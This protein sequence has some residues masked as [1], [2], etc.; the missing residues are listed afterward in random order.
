MPPRKASVIA[1]LNLKT[2]MVTVDL[3]SGQITSDTI[4]KKSGYPTITLDDLSTAVKVALSNEQVKDSI[5]HRGVALSDLTCVP[6]SAGWFGP[7]EENGRVIKVICFSNQGT[8]NF[9][10]RPIEG[11]TVTVDIDRK[12]VVKISDTGRNIPI[13]RS[14]NTDYTYKGQAEKNPL[15]PISIEQ[16]NGPSFIVEDGH[17]V[18]WANWE[19]HLKADQRAGL[20]ISRAMVRDPVTDELRSVMYKGF[21]SELFVPYMDVDESWYFK[22]YMDAGEYGMGANAMPLVE[23]ND[24]PKYSYY[25]DGVFVAA[26]GKPFV[27]RNVICLFERYAGD[28]SWRHSELPVLGFQVNVVLDCSDAFRIRLQCFISTFWLNNRFK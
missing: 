23:F 18:R 20:V 8:P 14:T 3:D 19:F 26:D 10:M 1:R 5:L 21:S 16:P 12:K 17:L 28:I 7:D 22:S 11:L 25:M 24:C 4:H 9:F 2:H 13:P 27:Q 15:N 6:P